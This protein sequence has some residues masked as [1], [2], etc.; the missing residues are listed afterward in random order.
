MREL[1]EMDSRPGAGVQGKPSISQITADQLLQ[2]LVPIDLADKTAG[3]V[4]VGDVGRVLRQNIPYDLVDGI[5]TFF[6]ESVINIGEDPLHL[7][8]RIVRDLEFSCSV[9]QTSALLHK[10]GP[11]PLYTNW[12]HM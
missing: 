7:S 5:V 2:Q 1:H 9:K 12:G 4:V 6:A 3:I 11:T 10:L 8:F